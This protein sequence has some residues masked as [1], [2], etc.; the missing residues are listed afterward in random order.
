MVIDLHWPSPARKSIMPVFLPFLGCPARCVFC[1]Q[2]RQTGKSPLGG[3]EAL[4]ARLGEAER[5]LRIFFEKHGF[6]PELA[7]YGGT[8]TAIPDKAWRACLDF[9]ESC[10]KAGL[11]SSFRCST[12]P[13]ALD[14]GRLRDLRNSGCGL[15]ELGAQSFNS[16]V[17]S[18]SGRGY[19]GEEALEACRIVKSQGFELGVQLMPGMPGADPEVFINDAE[20][21]CAARP[22][23]MR[24][25]PCLVI[26]GSPLA[27]LWRRGL[28]KPWSLGEAARALAQAYNLAREA[29]AVVARIGLAKD[30][31]LYKSVLAG[32]VHDSLGSRVQGL[33]LFYAARGALPNRELKIKSMRVPSRAAGFFWGWRGE[34]KESWRGLGVSAENLAF[35]EE[36]LIRLEA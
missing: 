16:K 7:F 25:Y 29:G 35:W 17:L 9:V 36:S 11:I 34:L 27:D 2:D 14:R 1:A 20:K 3:A 26:S 12:R 28:F 22:A 13:D 15:I 21:A 10:W 6:S 31:G 23:I 33:A 8:F 19:A 5:G 32:P 18:L 24:F 4:K 30:E